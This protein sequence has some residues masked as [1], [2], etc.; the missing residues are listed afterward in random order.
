[1]SA[2]P[3]ETTTVRSVD[4]LPPVLKVRE[5]AGF[6]RCDPSTVYEMV[7]RGDLPAV[8]LGRTIRF[9]REGIARFMAD[10]APNA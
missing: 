9:T 3:I 7:N 5:V 1:M 6:L 4:D 2:E 8:R 10:D